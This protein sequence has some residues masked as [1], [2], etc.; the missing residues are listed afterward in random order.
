M[1]VID[2]HGA[3]VA[4]AACGTNRLSSGEF[5]PQASAAESAVHLSG[6][7][8]FGG[9]A[10]H[11]FGHQ[12]TRSLGRLA[13]LAGLDGLDGYE[14]FAPEAHDLPDQIRRYAEAE[15]IVTTD[16]SH[17]H[18]IALARQSSQQVVMIAR[19]D[20]APTNLINHLES[21]GTGLR[22][23]DFRYIQA[24]RKEWWPRARADNRSF[25]EIDFDALRRELTDCD[26]IGRDDSYCLEHPGCVPT[27]EIQGAR[28]TA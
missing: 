14:V 18:V 26:A 6:T 11:H 28:A 24:I 4:A 21:F 3:L 27:G 22:R 25:G 20:E 19:R 1:A 9:I 2:R 10:S 8:L 17:G 15:T 5:I 12:I 16:G 23:S 13:G 7:W